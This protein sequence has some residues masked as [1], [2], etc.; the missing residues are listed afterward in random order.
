[1]SVRY[2][3]EALVNK[4]KNWTSNTQVTVLGPNET[5]RLFEIIADESNDS[6]I[7]LPIIA[8]RRSGAYSILNT[9][10]KPMTFHGFTLDANDKIAD[11]LNAI[12]ISVHYQLD[13]YTR[14]LEEAD[15]YTRNLIFNIVNFPKVT[16]TFPYYDKKVS[17]DCNI[18]LNA[19]VEDNSDIPERLSPGQFTRLSLG[20]DIDD[21]YL[22]DIR[23][24]DV[25]SIEFTTQMKEDELR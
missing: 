5:N 18:R 25:Y 12:P 14:Y 16:I 3:D 6:P 10:K 15:E 13:V 8:L 22:F 1:M 24:R 19:E 23:Y 20:I 11:Q 9:N 17:H 7:K 2:Y 21:A 4:I